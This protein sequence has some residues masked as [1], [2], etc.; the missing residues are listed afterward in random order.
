MKYMTFPSSCAFAGVANLLSFAGAECSDREI[1]LEVA[2]PYLF[3]RDEQGGYLG[4][5]MIQT[6]E[7]FDLFLRPRGFH[8]AER[9]V[10]AADVPGLLLERTP[11]MLGLLVAPNQ[12]H[13]VIYTGQD[14]EG[15]Y[16]FLNNRRQ[17][18]PEPERLVLTGVA[19]SDRLEQ[20]VTLGWLEPAPPKAAALAP[21][22]AESVQV[23]QAMR[24]DLLAFCGTAHTHQELQQAL[25]PLFRPL[26]L[27]G[28]SM[29]ALL[30]ERELEQLLSGLQTELLTALRSGQ[31]IPAGALLSVPKLELAMQMYFALLVQ[32]RNSLN[33]EKNA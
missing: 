24:G 27:D 13:A 23:F 5:P 2:L 14:G 18:S 31:L 3:A 28:I 33:R 6:K 4:G 1:A 30:E 9:K 17:D 20:T 12:K 32:K 22:L 26:L 19:L 29:A 8:L 25:N 15:R 16:C 7:L 11:V 10:S 21:Y